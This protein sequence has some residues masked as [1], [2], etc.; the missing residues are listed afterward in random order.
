IT[1]AVV[2]LGFAAIASAAGCNPSFNVTA[3]PDCIEKCR[4]S[5]GKG[6]SADYTLDPNS[7]N[8]ITSLSYECEKGTPAYTTYMTQSGI[9]MMNCSADDQADFG[10][11]EHADICTWY[12]AHKSDTCADGS[13]GSTSSSG[14]AS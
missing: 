11:R 13:S 5:A 4:E 7:P 3:G 1:S 10:S 6:M 12:S 14:S 9:C 2:F 8:F